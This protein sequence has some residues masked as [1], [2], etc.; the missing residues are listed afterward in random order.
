VE[1]SSDKAQEKKRLK[2]Q[3]SDD[4]LSQFSALEASEFN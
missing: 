4:F 3:Q 1:R 2:F